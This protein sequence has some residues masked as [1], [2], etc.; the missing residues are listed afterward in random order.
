MDPFRR[1]RIG[2]KV[3][4]PAADAYA[5]AARFSR[6]NSASSGR[7]KPFASMF[8]CGFDQRPTSDVFGHC[9]RG[10]PCQWYSLKERAT[11]SEGA[12]TGTDVHDR[13]LAFVETEV[14]TVSTSLFGEL[15]LPLSISVN[16]EIRAVS[17]NFFSKH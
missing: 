4:A 8:R 6:R 5:P 12:V 15:A 1:E 11:N 17:V 13:A 2:L 16:R 10:I 3:R 14:P 7:R 9:L